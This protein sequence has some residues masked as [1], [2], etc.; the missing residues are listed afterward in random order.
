MRQFV[1]PACGAVNRTPEARDAAAAK[2]GRCG[3]KLF[4]GQPV[5]VTGAQL[6]AHRRSTRGGALLLDV[7][8]P[9]CGPCRAMAPQFAAA[10]A[11]LEPDVRLLKLNSDAEPQAAAALGVSSIPA[12]F[13][14]AEGQVVARHAG[15]MSAGQIEAWTR[16]SLAGAKPR[17][18]P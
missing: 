9:W 11:R 16:Q 5:E 1:C 4:G 18:E 6:D 10:A 2:C 13:L 14:I 3:D 7:W 12:L 15:A 17:R 8:A